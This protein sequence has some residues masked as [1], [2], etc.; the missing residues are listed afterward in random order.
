MNE[1]HQIRQTFW[2]SVNNPCKPDA[3][4]LCINDQASMRTANLNN[5]PCIMLSRGATFL[6][7]QKVF[8]DKKALKTKRK[9]FTSSE[10]QVLLTES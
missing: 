8:I 10:I 6:G 2:T 7:G 9:N 1:P 4:H 3:V 5:F